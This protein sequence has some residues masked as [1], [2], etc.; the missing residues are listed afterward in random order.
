MAKINITDRV[1]YDRETVF[2]TFRDDLV[3]LIPHLPDIKDIDVKERETVD[4]STLK[5]INLWKAEAEEIPRLA[6]SFIK[7]DMLEWT[8][9]ATWREDAWACDWRMEVG[10]LSDAVTCEGTTAYREAGSEATEVTIDGILEVDAKKIPGVPRLGA[11]KIGKVIEGFVVKL[12]TPNLTQVN[13]GMERYLD[14]Q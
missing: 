1:A 4:D 2:K 6:R 13:R 5:V 9:Y 10:F 7:P 3:A 12:I 14:G 11:G 8:D